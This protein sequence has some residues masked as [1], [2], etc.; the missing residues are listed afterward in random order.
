MADKMFDRDE[1]NSHLNN[2]IMSILVEEM[3][4]LREKI[5]KLCEEV[6][7]AKY[8][9]YIFSGALFGVGI[10]FL[11]VALT[12]VFSKPSDDWSTM[13]ISLGFGSASAT[14]FISVLLMNPIKKIQQ[15][16][17]DA[18]QAE[19]IFYSWQLGV[20][21]YIRAMDITE[22]ESIKE[23]AEKI[24]ELTATSIDLLEKYYE[25]EP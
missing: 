11:V 15:A 2:T 16:N 4:R 7:R 19:M 8:L 21:L 5:K 1:A 10:F 3:P 13:I 18:S 9:T 25:I 12:L 22:R 14:S 6:K 23:S 20:L 24:E 17:S